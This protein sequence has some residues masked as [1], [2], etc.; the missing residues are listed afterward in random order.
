M[1]ANKNID[2][3]LLENS[4]DLA[5]EGKDEWQRLPMA[6]ISGY[7]RAQRP[8]ITLRG[9]GLMASISSCER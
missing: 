2:A 8:G 5:R 3:Q 7:I 9:Y 4:E 6:T 1:D